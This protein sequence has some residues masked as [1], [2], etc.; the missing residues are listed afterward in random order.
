MAPR[1]RTKLPSRLEAFFQRQVKRIVGEPR[2]TAYLIT[3]LVTL[4]QYV[5][6][7]ERNLKDRWRQHI[8]DGYKGSGYSI[9]QA[10]HEYGV[11]NFQFE[12]IAC[13][14][15]LDDLIELEKQL[16]DQYHTV[17]S[18]YN[19]T[20]GGAKA[21]APGDD[22]IINGMYFISFNA[23]CRHFG[24]DTQIAH[25]RK[26]R[27]GWSIEQALGL[28]PAPKTEPRRNPF[29]LVGHEYPNFKAACAAYGLEDGTVRSR[30][31]NGW[32]KEQ[33]FGIDPSPERAPQ[34][35]VKAIING[36]EY[37]NAG[38]MAET[39]GINAATITRRLRAGWSP[40]QT[41]GLADAPKQSYVGKEVEFD[42]VI[43]PS[44]AALAREHGK[45]SN[46]VRERID[47]NWNIRQAI[48]LDPPPPP[49]GEKNGV[50]VEI[51]GRVYSSYSKLADAYGIPVKQLHK[52]YK[53]LGW[54]LEQALN[55]AP[56]PEKPSNHADV[57]DI[58]GVQYPSVL[59][60]CQAYSISV[61]AVNRRRK[62]GMSL[63]EAI[64][65]PSR[66][67]RK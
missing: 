46:L 39:F 4:K 31:K 66:K 62:Q 57:V 61:S 52:R 51:D 26:N 12:F 56:P 17:E 50:V 21:D 53:K 35:G 13:A 37:L 3:N 2:F 58:D 30:I 15:N 22:Y 34:E 54:T 28:E 60:A 32:S 23:A 67:G 5:G 33:A 65:T 14:R 43:Y 59:A 49:S 55:L 25:Q 8:R 10:M 29:E 40:E 1:T 16:I 9:H 7:T 41:V 18:G 48:G 44:I 45:D 63:T 42:G 19:L 27:Y 6:I 20:R 64:T 24:V 36:T 47:R 11:E 38:E